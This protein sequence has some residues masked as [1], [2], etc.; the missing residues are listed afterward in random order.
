MPPPYHASFGV[1]C[2]FQS[3]LGKRFSQLLKDRWQAI[4]TQDALNIYE[5]ALTR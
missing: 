4:M 5:N 1:K 3:L 2:T